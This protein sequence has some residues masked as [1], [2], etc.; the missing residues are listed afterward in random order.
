VTSIP[1]SEYRALPPVP[2]GETPGGAWLLFG[3][4]A[5]A[6]LLAEQYEANHRVLSQELEADQPPAVNVRPSRWPSLFAESL[7]QRLARQQKL[8]SDVHWGN[9]GFCVDLAFHHPRRIKDVTLGVL[10]D[11]TRFAQAEDPVE[12]EI[13]RT[14]VLES[15]G[16]RLHRVW[17][18]HFFRDREGATSMILK[19][20][21]KSLAN[22]T[23][24]DGIKVAGAE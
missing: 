5:Y 18:P 20:I 8:G 14:A 17:T 15:Q 2:P 7:G 3:Y 19:G 24:K 11:L 22:E 10:C 21:E 9:D 4:L 6:E 12:W 13:F 16:W 1:E 23:D